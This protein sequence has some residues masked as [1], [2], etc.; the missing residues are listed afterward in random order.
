MLEPRTVQSEPMTVAYLEMRGAYGQIPEGYARLYE[1]LAAVGFTP[2]G[3]PRAVYHTDPAQVPESEARWELWAPVAPGPL[4][5]ASDDQGRGV[6]VVS[7][8]TLVT[9]IHKG[10]YE[11]IGTTYEALWGWMAER[12]C[13]LTGPPEESYLTDPAEVPP[14]EYLTEVAFPIRMP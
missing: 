9:V 3:M 8:R 12:G 11:S 5:Q 6:K 2:E 10:T 13:E 7:A 4:P 1:W 14:E